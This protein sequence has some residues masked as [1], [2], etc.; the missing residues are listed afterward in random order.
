[1][2]FMGEEIFFPVEKIVSEVDKHVGFVPA[3]PPTP[4]LLIGCVHCSL[5]V[6]PCYTREPSALSKR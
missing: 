3:S 2:P 4:P 6:H 5:S 1:M